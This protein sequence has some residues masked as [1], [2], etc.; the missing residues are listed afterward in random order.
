MKDSIALYRNVLN[1]VYLKK[2]VMILFL[3]KIDV[4]RE[5]IQ[6]FPLTMCYPSYTGTQFTISLC[7]RWQGE[8]GIVSKL[9]KRGAPQG[10]LLPSLVITHWV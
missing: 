4:F 5:I 8:D 10:S 9:L 3:N 6:K 2:A 1:I 7:L